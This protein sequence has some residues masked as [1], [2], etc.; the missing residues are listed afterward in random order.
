[1][2]FQGIRREE[3]SLRSHF[4]FGFQYFK[5]LDILSALNKVNNSLGVGPD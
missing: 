5:V 4:K 2:E 1:M 3:V